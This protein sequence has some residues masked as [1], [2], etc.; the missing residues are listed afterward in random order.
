MTQPLAIGSIVGQPA[1]RHAFDGVSVVEATYKAGLIVSPHAHD[2]ILVSLVLRGDATEEYRGR[3]REL[4]AQSLLYTPAFETHG[5]RFLNPGRWLNIQLT[6]AWLTRLLAGQA[7]LAD[8]PQLL[9]NHTAVAW[10][11]RVGIELQE[12][13]AVSHIAMEGALVLLVAEL[14]RIKTQDERT[15]PRWLRV[16][17][18]AIEESTS[19]P[20]SVEALA[21]LGG[22]HPSHMLRLF[23]RFHGATVSNYVRQRRIARARTELAASNRS[24]SVIALDAGFSDQSHFTRVFKQVYGETPGQYARAVRGRHV[25]SGA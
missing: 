21:A 6:E 17:E 14:S 22:V 7:R 16:V 20:P 25:E 15:R 24:L 8:T 23:R 9:R 19:R 13:D 10:A 12:T 2:S 4:A 18:N 11:T 5:H 1:H 3:T